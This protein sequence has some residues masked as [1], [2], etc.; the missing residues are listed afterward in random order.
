MDAPYYEE[1]TFTFTL[2]RRTI[3]TIDPHVYIRNGKPCT[4]LIVQS[5]DDS[6]VVRIPVLK[7]TSTIIRNSKGYVQSA[8]CPRTSN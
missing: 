2:L 4:F 3:F 6:F 1:L 5:T 7:A 8:I